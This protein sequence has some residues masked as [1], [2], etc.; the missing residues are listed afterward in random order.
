MMSLRMLAR[1]WRAG[2]L[3]VLAAALAVAV[4]S[5]TSVAFFADRVSQ[6]LL[7]DAHQLL[8]ADLVLVAD[9]PWKSDVVQALTGVERA[10]AMSFI[11]MAR[12]AA[13]A[14][15]AGVKA[16]SENYPLRGRL[17]IAPAPGAPDAVAELGPAPGTVWV[18]ERL[19]TAL[20]APV[21]SSVRL[22]NSQLKVAAI[23]TLEPERT[24]NFFNIAPRLMMNL[25]DVPATGLVQA[26]SRIAYYLYAAGDA[27]R[28]S[29]VF[30]EV[31]G[32]LGRGE[33]IDTLESGRPDIRAA[34]E[35]AER[36]LALTALLAAVLAGVAIA[37]GTR[38]FVERHL[39]GCAVLRCLGATQARL[40]ALYGG[41]F[42]LLGAA[43]C[44]LGALIGFGAQA[45]IGA[46]LADLV[47]AELP[48]PT[49]WPAL[50]GFLVGLVLLLGFALPP[51]LQLKDVPALRVIRREAGGLKRGTLA[52]YAFGL[53]LLATL[54]VWQAGDAKL[55]LYIVGGFTVAVLVFFLV[56]WGLLHLLGRCRM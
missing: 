19:V 16:V 46:A 33:R 22:G 42:A 40:L 45:A 50:Q 8:G 34:I 35:R 47:R 53:F 7:R 26:G 23:L 28:I 51:L 18:E 25:A 55:G 37:L 54:L 14:Q 52:G 38:R 4:A 17:R 13:D 32:R 2:E 56:A 10:E 30:D 31:K 21:G 20:K 15:L 24:A 48:A 1:D 6:A 29:R 36:F 27:E 5:V 12:T 39:D 44:A 11:S 41:E 43:A 49:P 9:H 3:R